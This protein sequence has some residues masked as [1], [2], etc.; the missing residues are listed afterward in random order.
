MTHDAAQWDVGSLSLGRL[1]DRD[2]RCTIQR[3]SPRIN[4][5]IF[6]HMGKPCLV[7][8]RPQGGY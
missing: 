5:D 8:P 4:E 2:S 1:M 7:E 6:E 3:N